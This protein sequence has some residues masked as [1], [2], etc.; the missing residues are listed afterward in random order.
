MHSFASHPRSGISY[1]QSQAPLS[2]AFYDGRLSPSKALQIVTEYGIRWV[3]VPRG[4]PALLYMQNYQ[5]RAG[6][7]SL[8][9]YEI[10]G[11]TM[12]PYPR[13]RPF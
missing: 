12:K 1:Y 11:N 3:I 13:I 2:R 4:S 8:I 7:G 9:I 5:E 6:F 10:P